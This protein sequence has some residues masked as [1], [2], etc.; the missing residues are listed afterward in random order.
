MT[1][2]HKACTEY[3][4]VRRALG[5]KLS[6]Y[7]RLLGDFVGYLGRCDAPTITT[8]AALSWATGP[9]GV[10]L[11]YWASRLGAVRGFARHLQGADPAVEV[12]PANLLASGPCRR[13]AYQFSPQDLERLVG[14]AGR[15]TPALRGATYQAFFGLLICSGARVGEVTK[16]DRADV[17]L[18][19]GVVE[20]N[21]AKFRKHRRLPLHHT[22][23]VALE[24]YSRLRDELCPR[25]KVPAFFVS[26]RGTRLL[27]VVV[28]QVFRELVGGLGLEDQPGA[29]HPRVHDLRHHFIMATLADFHR[30]GADPQGKLPLLSAYVGHSDPA[31]TY[32][33][34][35]P[36]PELLALAAVRLEQFERERR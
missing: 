19:R 27:Y 23:V 1:D 28:N 32:H 3:L 5:F 21:D 26:A 31:W 9:Q 8:R 25:A 36:S 10:T 2:L 33:Y 12:P 17:D 18:A 29:G 14:A 7:D 15:L 34:F 35:Q 16:L 30:E 11:H 13:T 24:R 22:A 6:G 4:A 20:I